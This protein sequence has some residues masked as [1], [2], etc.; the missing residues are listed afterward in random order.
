MLVGTA[1]LAAAV[2]LWTGR[3]RRKAL[4]GTLATLPIACT[5]GAL[6]SVDFQSL[7]TPAILGWLGFWW[8]LRRPATAKWT[9][10]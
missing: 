6:S 8:F 1:L 7:L 2:G 5:V 4:L 3:M 9:T 10:R